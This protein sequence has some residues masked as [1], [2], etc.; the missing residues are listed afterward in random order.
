MKAK[1]L[2]RVARQMCEHT[3]WGGW[4]VGWLVGWLGGAPPPFANIFAFQANRFKIRCRKSGLC[5]ECWI[6]YELYKGCLTIADK[7]AWWT[8][9][10]CEL[11]AQDGTPCPKLT[12]NSR[13]A[14]Q[15]PLSVKS[16]YMS[17]SLNPVKGVI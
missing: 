16:G 6:E 2:G 9:C 5:S 8:M 11:L 7:I 1:G 17:F 14:V 15:R 10:P 3:K 13:I 12:W 4:L